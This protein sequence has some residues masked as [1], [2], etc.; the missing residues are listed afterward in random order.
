MTSSVSVASVELKAFSISPA[1]AKRLKLSRQEAANVW[2][3]PCPICHRMH[4]HGSAEGHRVAHCPP[5]YSPDGGYV[6]KYAGVATADDVVRWEAEAMAA[7]RREQ[8]AAT[9]HLRR[10][11]GGLAVN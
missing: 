1:A 6:L 8:E 11:K 2:L 7:F 4:R 9:A 10:R 5:A 3:A